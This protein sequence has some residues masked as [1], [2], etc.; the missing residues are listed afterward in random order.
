[1]DIHLIHNKNEFIQFYYYEKRTIKE[2]PSK[3]PCILTITR[4]DVGIMGDAYFHN[5]SYFPEHLKEDKEIEDYFSGI[6]YGAKL[7]SN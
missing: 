6:L 4:R 2:Y 5:I 3:Y 1:M 7:L